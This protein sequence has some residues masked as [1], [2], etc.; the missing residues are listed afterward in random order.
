MSLD[1]LLG[2]VQN[3]EPGAELRLFRQLRV[4]LL[5]FFKKRVEASDVEDLTQETMTI[6][7][8]K[9]QRKPFD[10]ARPSSFRSYVFVIASL[11]LKSARKAKRRH[12]EPPSLHGSWWDLPKSSPDEAMM[13]LQHTA[14]LRS[15]LAAIKTVYR[16]A[17]E[18][19]LRDEDP[20]EFA[21]AEGIELAT[22]RT[23]ISRGWALVSAEIQAQRR[24]PV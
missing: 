24:T 14:L 2:A 23:R 19:R 15:A 13:R 18:S 1:E 5:S 7:V 8:A 12:S 10:L 3:G 4:E 9:L 22:V 17:L 21:D 11:H 16:R 20:R 6:I